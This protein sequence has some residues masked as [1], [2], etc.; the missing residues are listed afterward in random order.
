MSFGPKR[1]TI[2]SSPKLT[3]MEDVEF[4]LDCTATEST[5]PLLVPPRYYV[6]VKIFRMVFGEFGAFFGQPKTNT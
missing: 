1:N 5:C 2:R 6:V 4:V 3:E